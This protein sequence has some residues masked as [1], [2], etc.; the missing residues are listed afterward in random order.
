MKR[1][2]QYSLTDDYGNP[3][4]STAPLPGSPSFI[5]PLLPST[6]SSSSFDWGGFFTNTTS[7]LLNLYGQIELAKIKGDYQTAAQLQTQ[8]NAIQAKQPT[9]QPTGTKAGIP[10]QYIMYGLI[11]FAVIIVIMLLKKR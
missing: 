6:P 8:Y 9:G 5:G 2:G 11:A 10:K 4:L 3:I 1:F 7:Q